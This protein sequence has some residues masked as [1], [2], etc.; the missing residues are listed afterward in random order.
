MEASVLV[1]NSYSSFSTDAKSVTVWVQRKWFAHIWPKCRTIELRKLRF[2][3]AICGITGSSP[4]APKGRSKTFVEAVPLL[5]PQ[6]ISSHLLTITGTVPSRLYPFKVVLLGF[7]RAV[8]H[9]K[10]LCS[11]KGH[12]L[13]SELICKICLFQVFDSVH[14]FYGYFQVKSA[15]FFTLKF[16]IF[17]APGRGI[18]RN[19]VRNWVLHHVENFITRWESSRVDF[20]TV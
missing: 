14:C 18:S 16:E 2:I 17:R 3:Y 8:A 19:W 20:W 9:S 4:F 15:P 12:L 13:L 1:K 10:E 6:V 11:T 5:H 7:P